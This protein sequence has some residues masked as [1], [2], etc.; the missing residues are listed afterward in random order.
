MSS[1]AQSALQI[2]TEIAETKR[3]WTAVEGDLPRNSQGACLVVTSAARGEG[4]SLVAAGFGILAAR[5]SRKRVVVA[6]LNWHRP[7]LQD[8]FDLQ[9][10]F[11][12]S[13]LRQA[14]PVADL[15]QPCGTNG[16]AVL[17]APIMSG[18]EAARMQGAD[19]E[20]GRAVVGHLRASFDLVIVDAASVFPANRNMMDPV[21][22]SHDADGVAMVVLANVTPRQEVKRARMTLETSG[23]RVLGLV[24]NQWQNP[25]C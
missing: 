10:A 8:F 1:A 22:L 17:T 4:K 3:M 5:L 19:G 7:A 13:R 21:A 16:L 2:F 12:L 9:P 20:L 6:D 14:T 25:V 23:A 24:L 15:A 18:D 11:D